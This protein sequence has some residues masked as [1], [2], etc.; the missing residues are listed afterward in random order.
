MPILNTVQL[1]ISRNLW[2][3]RRAWGAAIAMLYAANSH[4]QAITT[5]SN[6]SEARDCYLAAAS[7]AAKFSANQENLATCTRAL[8]HE[9]LT[10]TDKARTLI[11]RGIV[12]TALEKYQD[13]L[14]DYNAAS[15]LE[16][17]MPEAFIS[18]GNL[19]YLAEKYQR[20]ADEYSKAMK[21][22]FSRMHIAFYNRGISNEKLGN[23]DA[24]IA[25]IK[26]AL[27]LQPDFKQARDRLEFL[28]KPAK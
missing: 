23:K 15:V 25:D 26:E 22:D 4:A 11:N 2:L 24:A 19:W 3:N 18:R 27:K 17:D 21:M 1:F 13:A 6:S 5:I 14:A 7:A 12:L 20:A 9:I 10:R 28:S 16:P 8:D